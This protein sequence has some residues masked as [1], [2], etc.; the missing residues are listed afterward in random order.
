MSYFITAIRCSRLLWMAKRTWPQSV[1]ASSRHGSSTLHRCQSLG[2]TRSP[3]LLL[4]LVKDPR[5]AA[6]RGAPIDPKTR[7][8]RRVRTR[9][10]E[11]RRSSKH[12]PPQVLARRPRSMSD[13]HADVGTGDC[14]ITVS[15]SSDAAGSPSC[16]KPTGPSS[17][18]TKPATSTPQRS[19][20]ATSI[21]WPPFCAHSCPARIAA[22]VRRQPDRWKPRHRHP[23]P[24][25]RDPKNGPRA[26]FHEVPRCLTSRSMWIRSSGRRRSPRPTWP[27]AQGS[28]SA[29]SSR[30][31]RQGV[32]CGR[33]RQPRRETWYPT[34]AL[35]LARTAPQLTRVSEPC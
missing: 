23:P 5:A 11:L 10:L 12:Q 20:C 19:W 31:P 21:I 28:P 18:T 25:P 13:A 6:I 22:V 26:G 32:Y 9:A 2:S 7:R 30:V 35:V 33:N 17:T 4:Q 29:A 16:S 8:V 27:A 3:I 24:A 14:A 1:E 34:S 15:T